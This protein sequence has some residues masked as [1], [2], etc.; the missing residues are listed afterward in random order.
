MLAAIDQRR[1]G[2]H[3]RGAQ[4]VGAASGFAPAGAEGDVLQAAAL[5]AIS[6]AFD[7]EDG[8]VGVG[9]DDQAFLALAVGQVI[10]RRQCRVDQQAI[11]RQQHFE[12]R[13]RF[14]RQFM[15]AVEMHA[16]AEAASPRCIDFRPQHAIGD[17]TLKMEFFSGQPGFTVQLGGSCFY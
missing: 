6:T 17:F 16:M 1:P 13:A 10:D 11:A 14:Q 12:A 2:F 8:R 4:C 7:R 15:L 3:Q 9:E 5:E